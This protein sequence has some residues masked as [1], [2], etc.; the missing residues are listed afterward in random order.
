M[1]SQPAESSKPGEVSEV[2]SSEPEY[3]PPVESSDTQSSEPS[4]PPV[5][6]EPEERNAAYEEAMRLST[7]ARP[8]FDEF[9][10]CFG[11][12]GLVYTQPEG[13]EPITDPLGFSGGWKAMVIYN[14][15]NS[16]GTFIRELDNVDI[17]INGDTVDLT[18]D[19]YL[20]SVDSSEMTNEEGMPDTMFLGTIPEEYTG[21]G[22]RA[23]NG[24]RTVNM[25]YFWREGTSQYALGTLT[26]EDG[27]PAYIALTRP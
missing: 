16:A 7:S 22:F 11:Q 17:G 1:S 6:S 15:S 19:W 13:T 9:E 2:V 3:V 18:I 20:M 14:P 21:G 23:F 12:N 27:L 25:V 8:S 5:E 4:E 26:T 10:W 24:Q